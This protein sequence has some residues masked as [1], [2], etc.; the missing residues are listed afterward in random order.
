MLMLYPIRWV[1]FELLQIPS[2]IIWL[3]VVIF[4]STIVSY[5]MCGVCKLR[6]LRTVAGLFSLALL[7]HMHTIWE[8]SII[9]RMLYKSKTERL[10]IFQFEWNLIRL[11][12]MR[13]NFSIGNRKCKTVRNRI[14]EVAC[15]ENTQF[16]YFMFRQPHRR[17]SMTNISY[18]ILM[19]LTKLQHYTQ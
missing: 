1:Q 3:L 13:Y 5:R 17:F 2:S 15:A 18:G 10:K 6:V 11:Y 12:L 7:V 16:S 14:K 4:V 9:N 8:H 19:E